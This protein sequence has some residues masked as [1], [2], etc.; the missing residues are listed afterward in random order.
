MMRLHVKLALTWPESTTGG[1]EGVK[2]EAASTIATG[3]VSSRGK[4]EGVLGNR[5]TV[6]LVLKAVVWEMDLREGDQ[7]ES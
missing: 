6:K 3:L 4:Q 1:V 2:R 7:L 5:V